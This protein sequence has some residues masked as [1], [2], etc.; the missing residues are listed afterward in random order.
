[1]KAT[2]II[3]ILLLMGLL[4]NLGVVPGVSTLGQ[5]II[6]KVLPTDFGGEA[7]WSGLIE[8]AAGVLSLG[9]V[10]LGQKIPYATFFVLFMTFLTAPV[11][12]ITNSDLAMPSTVQAILGIVWFGMFISAAIGLFRSDA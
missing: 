6:N 3:V 10:L 12:I 8:L 9:V 11:G 2:T 4:F 5:N 7:D 1:M